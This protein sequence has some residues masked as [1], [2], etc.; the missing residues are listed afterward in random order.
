MP[1]ERLVQKRVI[2]VED[3]EHR[4]IALK[5]IGE[6]ANRLLIHRAAQSGKGREMPLALFV[7]GI[8]IVDVQPLTGKF[9]REPP[10][11]IIAQHPVRL[12]DQIRSLAPLQPS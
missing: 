6:K 9:R 2:R 10:S 4:T 11:A 1:G 8:K 5:Q 3:F 12:L 7:E